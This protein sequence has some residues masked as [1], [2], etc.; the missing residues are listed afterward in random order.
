M[1]YAKKTW[2]G[3]RSGEETRGHVLG[4]VI[5]YPEAKHA[6]AFGLGM[7]A[8]NRWTFLETAPQQIRFSCSGSPAAENASAPGKPRGLPIDRDSIPPAARC[9]IAENALAL[10]RGSFDG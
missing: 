7:A 1:L 10:C 3:G 6:R 5:D 2:P 8:R 9:A 4:G